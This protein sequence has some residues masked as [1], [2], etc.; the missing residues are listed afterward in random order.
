MTYKR[1]LNIVNIIFVYFFIGI[2]AMN[3]IE[4]N[5]FSLFIIFSISSIYVFFLV[6][7]TNF[8]YVEIDV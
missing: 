5:N 6:Y 3:L 2:V 1:F 4:K 7:K 8:P